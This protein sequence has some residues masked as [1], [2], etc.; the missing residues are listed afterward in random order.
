MK[1]IALLTLMSVFVINT[2][3]I[4]NPKNNLTL[5]QD[6]PADFKT[7]KIG[8]QIWMAANLDI[9]NYL[10]GDP[11][12][13]VHSAEDWEKYGEEKKGCWCWVE[14]NPLNSRFGKMY[15]YYALTDPRGLIPSGWHV[16]SEQEWDEM[17]KKLGGEFDAAEKL[18]NKTGWKGNDNGSNKSGFS[19]LPGGERS[20]DG[21]FSS[22]GNYVA[23]W[24]STQSI[25][26]KSAVQYSIMDYEGTITKY[27]SN[28]GFG[29]Y[30]RCIKD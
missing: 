23:W 16:P 22:F 18:K 29:F 11:V 24:S 28:K 21:K 14:N 13:E 3:N 17:I 19:A 1:S 8:A 20:Y 4:N 30:V 25:D 6:V 26:E 9:T 5:T 7:I 10:N 2:G 15:N 12:P 27:E